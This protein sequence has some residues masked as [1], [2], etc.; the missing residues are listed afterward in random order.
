MTQAAIEALLKQKIGLDAMSIGSSTITR[1]VQRRMANLGIKDINIYW[2]R[3]QA[4]SQEL[5]E[6]IEEAIVPETW[7]F[8]DRE[9]FVFLNRF[10]IKEWLPKNFNRMLRVLSVPCSTGEEPYSI[11]IAFLEA[12]LNLKNFIIDAVDL[13]KISL[14]KARQGNYTKNS[15]RG[16]LPN[17]TY[18][19]GENLQ[20]RYFQESD[21]KYQISD[22]VR[23][24]VN[25]LHGNLLDYHFWSDK[26]NYDIIF[27]RNVLIYFDDA[28]RKQTI[29]LLERLLTDTGLLFLGHSETLQIINSGFISIPHPLAFAYQKV[30]SKVE[31]R[32]NE[33]LAVGINPEAKINKLS[34]KPIV[35]LT[36]TPKLLTSTP[37]TELKLLTSSIQN[38]SQLADQGKLTEAAMICENYLKENRT[39]VEAY[40]LLGQVRLAEGNQDQ[41][42]ECFQKAIYLEPHHYEALIHLALIK[43]KNGDLAKAVLLRQRI[44]RLEN[45]RDKP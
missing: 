21:N 31:I 45:L 24:S 34:P 35:N 36:S 37:S 16:E 1:L 42:E 41:A 40:V 44:Q 27:C 33:K 8:R 18:S 14:E 7:F 22:L 17:F 10:V 29:Q 20:Q 6:L 13:S 25:F 26:R 2:R 39:S 43:E 15:F 23:P 11:A 38:A 4:S 28:V 5:E 30:P 3:L 32:V 9:P 19:K 12:G